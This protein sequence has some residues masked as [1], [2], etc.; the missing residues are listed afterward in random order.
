MNGWNIKQASPGATVWV[1]NAEGNPVCRLH[2]CNLDGE[3]ATL[4][5]AAPDLLAALERALW[6]VERFECETDASREIRTKSAAQINAAIAKAKG[7]A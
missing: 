5:A 3:R 7:E 1:E 6:Y 2:E 4:I